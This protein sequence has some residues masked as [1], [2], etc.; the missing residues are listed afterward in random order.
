MNEHNLLRRYAAGE[1]NFSGADLREIKLYGSQG[2]EINLRGANLSNADLEG[3]I[4]SHVNLNNVNL[5]NA[6]LKGARL[7]GYL[8]DADLSGADLTNVHISA[9]RLNRTNFRGANLTNANFGGNGLGSHDIDLSHADCTNAKLTCDLIGANFRGANL[10]SAIFRLQNLYW[11]RANMS[12]ANFSGLDLS[13]QNFAELDLSYANLSGANLSNTNLRGANLEGADLRSANLEGADLAYA[14][15]RSTQIEETIALESKSY[16]VWQIINQ[17]AE[18]QDLQGVDLSSVNLKSVNFSG[19]NLKRANLKGSNLV[20]AD[21]SGANLSYADLSNASLSNSNLERADLSGA[22]L[23]GASFR[24]ANLNQANL[25]HAYLLGADLE[26]AKLQDANLQHANLIDAKLEGTDLTDADLSD[27][28]LVGTKLFRTNLTNTLNASVSIFTNSADNPN[29]ELLNAI[30]Q[31]SQGLYY[32]SES[33]Y[34]YEVFLWEV[35]TRGEFT[36]EVLLQSFGHLRAIELDEFYSGDINNIEWLKP[37]ANQPGILR[38]TQEVIQEFRT[39][40][41]QLEPYL[42]NLQVYRLMIPAQELYILTGNTQVADWV[43]VSIKVSSY[44]EQQHYSSAIFR[45]RDM[46]LA[47]PENRELIT[48]LESAI[49]GVSF[50]SEYL[51]C[52]VW[53]IAEQRQIVLQNLLDTT[54]IITINELQNLFGSG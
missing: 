27:A 53:E 10:K 52:F 2:K 51:E 1:R 5:R 28:N 14:N 49:A 33:D 46:A 38:T 29:L 32:G 41:T 36:L 23:G 34:P 47:K 20:Q 54:R 21:L 4:L 7:N 40:I 19:I 37:L 30:R 13:D 48:S 3:A 24:N 12:R 6:N 31:A 11:Y 16:L 42:T 44:L 22:Q 9:C 25:S 15:L 43:G 8:N 45:V 26:Q 50:S 17:E 35:A 18:I 39:L